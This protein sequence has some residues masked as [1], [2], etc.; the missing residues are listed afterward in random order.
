MTGKKLSRAE[1]RRQQKL[2]KASGLTASQPIAKPW[3]KMGA[4]L[5]LTGALIGGAAL[6]KRHVAQ[7]EAE[8]AAD[9]TLAE[10]LHRA[11]IAAVAR[12]ASHAPPE[13]YDATPSL[14][15]LVE[16]DKFHIIE[17]DIKKAANDSSAF[18]KFRA[19]ADRSIADKTSHLHYTKLTVA[20]VMPNNAVFHDLEKELNEELH[21]FAS[22]IEPFSS[23]K[24]VHT[25]IIVTEPDQI[26]HPNVPA[27][28]V[29]MFLV[30]S[31]ADYSVFT[32]LM[33]NSKVLVS[34]GPYEDLGSV[35]IDIRFETNKLTEAER[36]EIF[37]TPRKRDKEYQTSALLNTAIAE[38]LHALFF[39]EKAAKLVEVLNT[40][41]GVNGFD[42]EK[43]NAFRKSYI[44]AEEGL[45][46]AAALTYL[47]QFPKH[48]EFVKHA[49]KRYSEQHKYTA[50]FFESVRSFRLEGKGF[51][52]QGRVLALLEM[53]R[54]Q[55]LDYLLTENGVNTDAVTNYLR[56]VAPTRA[57]PTK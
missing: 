19:M 57:S 42:H 34:D 27:G 36:K 1:Q 31:V 29:L 25:V 23:Q 44:E 49:L 53:V 5:A 37:I 4:A 12:A 43:V 51:N 50:P 6:Y 22:Y 17:A 16:N 26:Q 48:K 18:Y 55:R 3:Y 21:A 2:E 33:D 38:Y 40:Y 32:G 7:Q 46:H 11:H 9:D 56:D 10:Q 52:I 45:I 14:A 30:N 54:D 13:N 39:Q 41:N 28:H 24:A 35:E 15:D 20:S 47:A 8:Q